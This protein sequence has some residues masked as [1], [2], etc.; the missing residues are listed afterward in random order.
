[1]GCTRHTHSGSISSG[2]RLVTRIRK[3]A[4]HQNPQIP[5]PPG[6]LI[7]STAGRFQNVFTVVEN[8]QRPAIRH[9]LGDSIKAS[10]RPGP[11][12]PDPLN[13]GGNHLL[14]GTAWHQID[15][16]RPLR[17][18]GRYLGPCRLNRQRGLPDPPEACRQPPRGLRFSR[19]KRTVSG[20]AAP[21]GPGRHHR[22]DRRTGRGPPPPANP[23]AL[24]RSQP[25]KQDASGGRLS[26][27]GHNDANPRPA[28]ATPTSI[29]RVTADDGGK[30]MR[31][32]RQ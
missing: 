1:M 15:A 17:P 11:P 27:G 32:T 9:R 16:A 14:L 22:H 10:R 6:Q 29:A 24:T 18:P 21:H 12:D 20:A 3:S 5:S 8:E 28:P 2:M 23:T 26:P 30:N 31:S 25:S 13:Q 19:Q 4:A 7:A